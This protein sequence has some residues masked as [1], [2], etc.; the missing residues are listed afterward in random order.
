MKVKLS[1]W[2]YYDIT[3]SR[4]E[5]RKEKKK[6]NKNMWPRKNKNLHKKLKLRSMC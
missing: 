3:K 1:G 5:G 6:R 4:G 2:K